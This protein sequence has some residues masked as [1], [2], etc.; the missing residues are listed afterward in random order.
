MFISLQLETLRDSFPPSDKSLSRLLGEVP[1]LPNSILKLLECMCSPGNCDKA[2]KEVQSGDRVTQGLSTVWSLILLRPP[3]RDACLKIALQVFFFFH[4]FF[5]FPLSRTVSCPF[6]WFLFIFSLIP[7]NCLLFHFYYRKLISFCYF[8]I[9]CMCVHN[10]KKKKNV[11][12]TLFA[13]IHFLLKNFVISNLKSI[14][15]SSSFS[16][17]LLLW[18]F[19]FKFLYSTFIFI[20]SF[21]SFDTSSLP[22]KERSSSSGGSAN[23]GYTSGI[24]STDSKV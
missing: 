21:L 22:M 7:S 17:W 2:E 14:S 4:F 10:K 6:A 24:L 12:P 8:G 16:F 3:F 11:K 9:T 5:Q 18:F 20:F 1:Y 23:E 15:M 19:S 13:P